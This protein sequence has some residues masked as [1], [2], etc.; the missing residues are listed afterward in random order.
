MSQQSCYLEIGQSS[1]RALHD[2][3]GLEL[4]LERLP[5]GRLTANCRQTITL[6]LQGFFR[7][8]AWQPRAR[9]FCA[10][11]ARGV[12]VR[13]LTLPATNRENLQ[14]VLFL[15]LENEFP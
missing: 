7:K 2:D 5:N 6:S 3:G 9:V 8:K 10:I 11:S 1:L 15:Q 4:P 14:R 12:S 13:R